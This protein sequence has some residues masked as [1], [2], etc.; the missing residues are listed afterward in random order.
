MCQSESVKGLFVDTVARD[1]NRLFR[2]FSAFVEFEIVQNN[3]QSDRG[4]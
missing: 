4:L 2:S 1:G 3:E